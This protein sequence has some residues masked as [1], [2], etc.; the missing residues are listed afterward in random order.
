VP[1]NLGSGQYAKAH[2]GVPWAT[3]HYAGR[4]LRDPAAGRALAGR[5]RVLTGTAQGSSARAWRGTHS[6][7]FPWPPQEVLWHGR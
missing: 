1:V 7:G 5:R 6:A 4:Q 3:G 2:I